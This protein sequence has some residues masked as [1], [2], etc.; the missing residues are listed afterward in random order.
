MK[1][2]IFSRLALGI[3]TGTLLLGACM[4]TSSRAQDANSQIYGESN[5]VEEM[6]ENLISLNRAKNLA[7]M[8]AENANGGLGNY[9]A[10]TSMH[11][12]AEDAPFVDNGNGTWTFTF[13]G[14][15]PG[16]DV[17]AFR[18]VVTVS[19]DGET[20]TMDSNSRL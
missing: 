3:L 2:N 18:S 14:T 11:R 10:E 20:V 17:P 1:L 4:G 9:R 13:T 6:Y 12:A 15:R 7:R 5:N 8:A 19:Q 16:S